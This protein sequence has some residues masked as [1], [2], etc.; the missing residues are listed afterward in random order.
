[1]ILWTSRHHIVLLFHIP[2]ASII[3][4]DYIDSG[5]QTGHVLLV[6]AAWYKPQRPSGTQV[7]SIIA[8]DRDTKRAYCHHDE[9]WY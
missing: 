2:A 8:V 7:M 1:M 9:L 3:P 5:L 6:N 4:G